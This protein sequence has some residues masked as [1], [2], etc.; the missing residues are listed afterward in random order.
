MHI[1]SDE[2]LTW[3]QIYTILGHAAGVEPYLVHVPSDTIAV[4]DADV[5]A[6]LL[7]DKA[8]SVIF[9][10]TKIK[11]LVPDYVA[12]TPFAQGAREIIAWFDADPARQVIDDRMN[13]LF[14]NI[15]IAH[16]AALSRLVAD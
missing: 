8:Y 10:N 13:R 9:D 7:G 16:D 12:A 11:R 6:G 14:D 3:N 1:T 4:F 15:L 5:G 2:V